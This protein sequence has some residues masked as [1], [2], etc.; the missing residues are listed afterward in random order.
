MKL[1]KVRHAIIL[2]STFHTLD[3][4]K[5]VHEQKFGDLYNCKKKKKKKTILWSLRA[6]SV[7]PVQ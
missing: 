5:A 7:K 4:T 6:V 2:K 3:A 1:T